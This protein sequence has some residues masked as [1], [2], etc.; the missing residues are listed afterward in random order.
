MFKSDNI[1]RTFNWIVLSL[2]LFYACAPSRIVK[3]LSK[4]QKVVTGSFGGS[5]IKFAGAPIPLPF[6]TLSYG[7][8]LTDK[9]TA[10][11]SLHTTSLLF[12]NFQTDIGICADVFK[13]DKFGFSVSPTL[14]TAVSYKDINSFRMW[15]SLDLNLRYEFNKGFMYTGMHNW[16]E[17]NKS[18]V[19]NTSIERTLLPNYHLGFVKE[20][21]KWNHQ[22]EVKYMLPGQAIYPGVVDYI[23]INK[24]GA[25]GI[26]YC[27][28]RKF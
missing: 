25:I 20:N 10:F 3:P 28:I 13:K 5:L 4:G 6:S 16:F 21:T 23:G 24:K 11:G 2:F 8:G 1:I 9:I 22:F 26:Y 15:P 27:L 19:N 12:G 18:G 17:L 14:Q 7:N